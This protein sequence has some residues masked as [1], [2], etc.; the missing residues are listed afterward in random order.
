MGPGM[1]NYR[2]TIG[3]IGLPGCLLAAKHLEATW[4]RG[5]RGRKTRRKTGC[6][7]HMWSLTW[8]CGASLG[9]SRWTRNT[10]ERTPALVASC[11]VMEATPEDIGRNAVPLSQERDMARSAMHTWVHLRSVGAPPQQPGHPS[12]R[13]GLVPCRS[14]EFL[15]P[16]YVHYISMHHPPPYHHPKLKSSPSPRI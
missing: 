12:T 11:S 2:S 5:T 16:V 14:T 9:G 4:S 10:E 1:A 7:V 6:P 8:T 13:E 15:A 3:L